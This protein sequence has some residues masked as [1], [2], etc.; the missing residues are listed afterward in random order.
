M[1][2]FKFLPANAGAN[3][4]NGPTGSPGQVAMVS[5]Q[6]YEVSDGWAE[7]VNGQ[8][9]GIGD[10]PA[11]VAIVAKADKPAPPAKPARANASK[12]QPAAPADPS[13]ETT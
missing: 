2:L 10:E 12:V 9:E 3:P 5:G 4:A 8:Y 1:G 6:T 13:V 11:L 7:H